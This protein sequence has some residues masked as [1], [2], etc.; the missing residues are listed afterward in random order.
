MFKHII[1]HTVFQAFVIL[2][3]TFTAEHFM[4]ESIL[5]SN[6]IVQKRFKENGGNEAVWKYYENGLRLNPYKSI[7]DMQ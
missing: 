7:I 2:V 6:Q 4:P 1:V 5:D 3:M